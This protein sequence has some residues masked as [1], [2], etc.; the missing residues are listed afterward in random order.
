MILRRLKRFKLAA[1][2]MAVLAV[3]GVS[4]GGAAAVT[5]PGYDTMRI[6]QDGVAM[7]YQVWT[8]WAPYVLP[9]PDG[10][11]WSFFSAQTKVPNPE[12]PSETLFGTRKLY[13]SHFDPASGTW[14]PATAFSGGQIQF[15]PNALVDGAGTVHLV[16]TDR[17][18]AEDGSFGQLVYR[19]STADGGWTDPVTVAPNE[20]AG[21]Q[22]SP[23]LVLD[24]Q[25]G[26]HVA[27]QDQRNVTEDRRIGANANA[28]NADVFASDLLPD[29]T[30]SEPVQMNVR[31]DETTNASRP[32]L[33]VDGDR[34]VV[35]W[36]V[37]DETNGLTSAARVE[38]SS[39]P[40][41]D[42][43]TWAPAQTLFSRDDAQ[44]GGRFLDVAPDPTG[45]V[46]II[47]GRRTA[48]DDVTTN[49]LYL[50]RLAAGGNDWGQP[51]S[52]ISGNRGSYPR[53]AVGLDGTAYV[54][55]NLGSNSTVHVGA[56]A[57]APGQTRASAEVTVTA[58]EEGAQGIGALAVDP[59]NAVWIVYMHEPTGGQ[60]NEV[61]VLRGAVIPSEPAPETP[62]ATPA[63]SPEPEA[64]PSA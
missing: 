9:M 5:Q 47:Y 59:N 37:Y 2:T 4:V 33:V 46:T 24:G 49:T 21:H 22:L 32:Q 52:L 53:L 63:A 60:A 35:I 18:D 15:G 42:P 57:L 30:W 16:Y 36:S 61:R 19:K 26:I 50:Q 39:R 7:P 3:V 8:D 20:A 41:A 44:I 62:V 14:Q 64:S 6:D 56:I 27:W 31:P 1:M 12:N 23:E 43:A 25:G 58:G 51:I 54:I 34:L 28:S 11:A 29:G 40:L 55:Y 10:G 48:T 17:L 45:G 13:A 38:W